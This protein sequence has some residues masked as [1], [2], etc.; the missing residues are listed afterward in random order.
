[1]T[2]IS[3]QVLIKASPKKVWDALADFGNVYKLSAGVTKSYLTSDQKSGVGAT[4]HCDLVN[5]NAQLEERIT[6]WDEGKS[7]KVD[8][9][10]ATLPLVTG[11]KA[12]FKLIP[13][14]DDTLLVGGFQYKMKN[15][16]GDLM[17]ITFMKRMNKKAWTTF[18]AGVKHH[19]ETGEE[20][21]KNTKVDTSTVKKV[22]D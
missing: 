1:M 2:R 4:R 10:K 14:G 22:S 11:M 21:T 13:Q 15:V 3:R 19:V 5:M 16:I 20:I 6:E 8:V 7:M 9:Y 17:N 12:G 18:L